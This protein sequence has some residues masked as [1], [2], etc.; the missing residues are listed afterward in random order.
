MYSYYLSSN[1]RHAEALSASRQASELDPLSLST[2]V[3]L[4]TAYYFVRQYDEAIAV[5]Q[6]VLALEPAFRTALMYLGAAY[7]N[8][9]QPQEA[10]L[11]LEKAGIHHP[12][13]TTIWAWLGEAYAKAGMREKAFAVIG[14][15]E[16][17]SKL[18]YVSPFDFALAHAGLKQ[19]NEAFQWLERAYQERSPFLVFLPVEPTLDHLRD[20]PRFASLSHRI[21]FAQKL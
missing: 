15:L 9:F 3:S 19:N 8:N 7:S 20:D 16:T 4:G 17:L 14:K 18:R 5:L 2:S 11:T 6:K 1:G 10:I 12:T 21:G 13:N